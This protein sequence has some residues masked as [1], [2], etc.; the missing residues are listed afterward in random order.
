M[1]KREAILYS[2]LI[3]GSPSNDTFKW[4][5]PYKYR[6]PTTTSMTALLRPNLVM[7]NNVDMIIV[8]TNSNDD[9]RTI[10]LGTTRSVKSLSSSAP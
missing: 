2:M 10:P 8:V 7:F 5:N 9:E 4:I 6:N 1:V 3:Q